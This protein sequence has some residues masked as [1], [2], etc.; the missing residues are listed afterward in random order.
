MRHSCTF[1]NLVNAH[2]FAPKNLPLG[3]LLLFY[4]KCS[5]HSG[6]L[7]IHYGL[8]QFRL[9]IPNSLDASFISA[10]SLIISMYD[11][12]SKDSLSNRLIILLPKSR[13]ILCRNVASGH[14]LMLATFEWLIDFNRVSLW[15]CHISPFQ[16]KTSTLKL[17]IYTYCPSTNCPSVKSLST[18]SL[19]AIS[20]RPYHFWPNRIH[21][22]FESSMQYPENIW[23]RATFNKGVQCH[24]IG[25]SRCI[26]KAG[27]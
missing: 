16:S 25:A 18:K 22:N 14:S 13:Q 15:K 6:R 10:L 9:K 5:R 19:S 2:I 20:R 4:C 17:V 27:I 7:M 23:I 24:I 3:K 21:L 8:G 11:S 1:I 12:L 26:T